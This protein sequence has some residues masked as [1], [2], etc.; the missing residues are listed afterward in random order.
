MLLSP[1]RTC[2]SMGLCASNLCFVSPAA[3]VAVVIIII[4]VIL[5][6]VIIIVVVVI[7][8]ILI[9]IIIT[10]IIIVVII[11]IV[12]LFV[13]RSPG[14][15]ARQCSWE[16]PGGASP[17]STTLLYPPLAN[18]TDIHFNVEIREHKMLQAFLSFIGC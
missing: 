9:I 15:G 6:V 10:I 2:S 14:R 18:I 5:I 17:P 4:V 1:G 7:I 16:H 13:L 8:I 12:I 11:I 3:L